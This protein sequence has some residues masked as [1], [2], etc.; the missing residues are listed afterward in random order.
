[1]VQHHFSF[2]SEKHAG[3]FNYSL[4][5]SY[6]I[7]KWQFFYFDDNL[8]WQ[9]AVYMVISVVVSSR[10]WAG[11]VELKNMEVRGQS[12]TGEVYINNGVEMKCLCAEG[13]DTYAATAF[14]KMVG[15]R[16]VSNTIKPEQY[17]IIKGLQLE[18]PKC[19]FTD[20]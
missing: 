4:I 7:V 3:S 17:V 6:K 11:R 2:Y 12:M 20:I 1:M 9:S 10:S 16:S 18:I 19:T 14:C 15:F 8:E 13:W 5:I